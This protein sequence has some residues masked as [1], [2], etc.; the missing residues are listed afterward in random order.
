ME[1]RFLFLPFG[2][3]VAVIGL[4]TLYLLY[5]LVRIFFYKKTT[6]TIVKSQVKKVENQIAY[7]AYY[8]L[9]EYEY[10]VNG[11]KYRS[12]RIF[13]TNLESD[14]NTIKKIV[15]KFPE[16]KK[17]DIYYNPFKPEDSLLKRNYHTGMFIQTLV[18]F[19]MLSVFLYTLFIEV[20]NPEV[21]L[22][23]LA[24]TVKSWLH[25]IIYG[26]E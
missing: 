21:D 17:I 8:P 5:R 16:G 23:K 7:E 1:D 2:F 19:G 6:G 10:E 24:M 20:I 14:Y 15:D 22:T 3:W 4:I 9:V 13:L 25:K 11:K 18:F 26:E 12:N